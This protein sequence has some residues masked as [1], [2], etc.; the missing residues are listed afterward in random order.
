MHIHLSRRCIWPIGL[1]P[2][3][4]EKSG[5]NIYI[6]EC[7]NLAFWRNTLTLLTI[8]VTPGRRTMPSLPSFDALLTIS[9]SNLCASDL[10]CVN[11]WTTLGCPRLSENLTSS[12]SGSVIPQYILKLSTVRTPWEATDVNQWAINI[13]SHKTTYYSGSP[14][15]SDP[16]TSPWRYAKPQPHQQ[17]S[18]PEC[19]PYQKVCKVESMR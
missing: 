19:H 2:P 8:S 13:K 7:M 3:R 14:P 11:S 9:S 12:S 15:H 4:R 18:R 1:Q 10:M 16:D 5:C 17:L 6:Y